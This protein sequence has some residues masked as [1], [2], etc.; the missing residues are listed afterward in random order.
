MTFFVF[1]GPR[2]LN[3][4]S[5]KSV[6]PVNK[7]YKYNSEDEAIAIKLKLHEQIAVPNEFFYLNGGCYFLPVVESAS[8][9]QLV[10]LATYDETEKSDCILACH[11]NIA[12]AECSM[13]ENGMKGKCLLSG[14]HFEIDAAHLDSNNENLR[15]NVL[16]KLRNSSQ[17]QSDIHS[18]YTF[19]RQLFHRVFNMESIPDD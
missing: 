13:G 14:V 17:G 12:I 8:N 19:I 10:V 15:M 7:R 6:G 5:G 11:T 3:F 1:S 4:L 2:E 18:N 9:Q 16:E